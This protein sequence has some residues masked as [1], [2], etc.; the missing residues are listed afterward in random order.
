MTKKQRKQLDKE[1]WDDNNADYAIV[2]EKADVI[3]KLPGIGIVYLQLQAGSK[4]P[5][6]IFAK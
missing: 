2:V 6:N 3:V 1:Y 5:L 4:L